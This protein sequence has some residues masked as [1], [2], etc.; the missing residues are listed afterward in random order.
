MQTKVTSSFVE[1]DDDEAA[2]ITHSLSLALSSFA[3]AIACSFFP[4]YR[5]SA[6]IW[7]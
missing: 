5:V 4:C 1:D 7:A 3:L 6:E 2:M